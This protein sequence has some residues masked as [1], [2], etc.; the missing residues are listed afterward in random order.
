MTTQQRLAA[1]HVS[2][3][4]M[5]YL[6]EPYRDPTDGG[7]AGQVWHRICSGLQNNN[8]CTNAQIAFY[9]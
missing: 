6:N 2:G 4:V 9:E 8:A 3:T 7:H 5:C 1:M